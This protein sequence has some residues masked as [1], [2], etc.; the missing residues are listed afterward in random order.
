M[1]HLRNADL[2]HSNLPEK[3]ER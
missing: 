3:Q 1:R 2:L